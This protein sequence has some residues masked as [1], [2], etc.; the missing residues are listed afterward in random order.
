MG[1]KIK[2]LFSE[3]R[4]IGIWIFIR[5]WSWLRPRFGSVGLLRILVLRRRQI[6]H[7]HAVW[8]HADPA[9]LDF[10]S[11]EFA[12][13]VL[14]TVH[15]GATGNQHSHTFLEQLLIMLGVLVPPLHIRPKTATIFVAAVPLSTIA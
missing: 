10:Q 7:G 1:R 15:N 12:I 8:Q 3:L 9:G 6:H 13:V 14:P 11:F 2:P 5:A 4:W